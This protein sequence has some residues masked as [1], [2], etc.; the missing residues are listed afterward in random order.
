[1]TRVHLSCLL[2]LPFAVGASEAWFG[3]KPPEDAIPRF[4]REW[5]AYRQPD[6]PP[7]ESPLAATPDPYAQIRGSDVFQHLADIMRITEENRAAGERFWGRIAGTDAERRTAEYLAGRFRDAG[8]QSVRLEDVHGGAQWWPTDWQVTLLAD[9]GAGAGSADYTLASAFPALQLGEG[10]MQVEKLAA[11]LVYAGLGQP[12]DL[13]GRELAGRIAVV[14]SVL[15]A[16]PFFQTARGHIGDIVRAGAVGVIVAIDAPGNFQYALENLGS[17]E[18]P[19]FLVGGDDG[20][21]LQQVLGAA[22]TRPV[23]VRMAMRS[24]L[25][26]S[27]R[28]LN[29]VAVLPGRTEDAVL[30]IA[31]LDGYFHAANDNGGGLASLISL[32][33]HFGKRPRTLK[34]Q[35]VFVGTSGHHEFSDGVRRFIA[36]HPDLMAKTQLVMNLEHPSSLYSYYRGPLRLDRASVPGQLVTTTG[37]GTRAVSISNGNARLL[38]IYRDAIHRRGIVVDATV[39]QRPTGDAF[40]FFRTGLPVVQIIDANLWFHS[41]ADR[42]ETIHPAGLERATRLYAEILD[43]IDE[44]SSAELGLGPR[45]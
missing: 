39:N 36:A 37:Q 7:L 45:R 5:A 38:A 28:G 27:W 20:R 15:Q 4:E 22:G 34:R 6:F 11:A 26:P 16:D 40:D 23:R 29:A 8:L 3:V 14:R 30:V 25:R 19:C 12:A 43:T 41:S 13:A 9:P 10:A 44:V 35:H 18:V 24:E 1:M 33:H 2:W 21:F 42:I 17:T 31:H 32:A